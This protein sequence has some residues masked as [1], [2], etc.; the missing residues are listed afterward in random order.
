MTMLCTNCCRLVRCPCSKMYI[1]HQASVMQSYR[2]KR[3]F[4]QKSNPKSICPT[5]LMHTLHLVFFYPSNLMQFWDKVIRIYCISSLF[6]LQTVYLGKNM[7]NKYLCYFTAL[8]NYPSC[9]WHC[10][11]MSLTG[12][13]LTEPL[14]ITNNIV[15]DLCW[16]VIMKPFTT[17]IFVACPWD[18]D[19]SSHCRCSGHCRG[20]D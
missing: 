6:C 1:K 8:N 20:W 2:C 13:L 10:V 7:P 15:L 16:M 17:N 5:F 19:C 3:V 12:F 9:Y 4:L 18:G 14:Q 11:Y